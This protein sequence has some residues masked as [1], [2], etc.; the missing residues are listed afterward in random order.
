M[1]NISAE[2]GGMQTIAKN[3]SNLANDYIS[4]INGVYK[5]ISDLENN[6][7]G[8]DNVAYVNKANEYREDLMALGEAINNYGMFLDQAAVT[9]STT[10][11]DIAANARR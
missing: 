2:Y 8:V 9:T 7:K 4:N 5:I 3:I 11:E 1:A 6:W 10:Q